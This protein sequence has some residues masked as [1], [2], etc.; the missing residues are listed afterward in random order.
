MAIRETLDVGW[1]DT[2]AQYVPGQSFDITDLPDGTYY[3]QVVANPDRRLYERST[4]NNV[5]Y[6]KVVLGTAVGGARTVTV[7]PHY[8][9]DAP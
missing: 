3:I 9:V 2:Y 6:R 8:G 7:P 4:R 1:G 5:S